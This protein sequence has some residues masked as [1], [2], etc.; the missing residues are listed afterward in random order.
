M[1]LDIIW[2]VLKVLLIV[3]PL[4][5][6]VAYYTY[7]ERKVIGYMQDRIGPNRVG[8]FGLLQPIVDAVKL[9]LKEIIIPAKSNR[10]LFFIAPMLAFA[11]A[12]TAWAVVPFG[13]GIV[14]A[15]I[16]A[17]VL[18]ILAM[19]SIAVYGVIIAGW[20]SN[21]KYAMFGALR[22]AAQVVSYELAMGF[23]IIGVLIAAGSL[24]LSTI[25]ETQQGG[26]WHW[27][28]IPL[29]PLFVIYFISG[30]AETGRAPFDVIEGESE[31]IAGHHVEY[32][33]ARFALFFLAEYANMI[34]IS[35][36]TAV[37]FLGGWISPFQN[38]PVLDQFFSFVPGM[39]WL[40]LKTGIFMFMYLWI[41]ATFPRYR[42][43]QL[44]RL[45]WKIFIPVT[46]VW[47]IVV[48]F[49]VKLGLGPWW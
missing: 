48:A 37:F 18:Y 49:M 13:K 7:A 28:F 35:L 42:Y 22:A 44:M 43:D 46:L 19:T 39:I 34:L 5:L 6:V 1:I 23:A 32:S 2:I 26:I 40:F 31:I 47:V 36:L 41:R 14:L 33:G 20:A 8:S 17:G 25:V 16:N 11:P 15:D 38:I 24:N 3:I 9:L 21:S 27:Y 30:V 10:Y 29:F 45:G 12:Y 4:I